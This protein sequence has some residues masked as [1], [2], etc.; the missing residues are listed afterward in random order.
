MFSINL[1]CLVVVVYQIY[2]VK[3]YYDDE[4]K[5]LATSDRNVITQSSM[6]NPPYVTISSQAVQAPVY[7]AQ[8]I[9]YVIH[10]IHQPATQAPYPQQTYQYQPQ[11]QPAP[12]HTLPTD[13][14][15]PQEYCNPPPYSPSFLPESS[16]SSV[17]Q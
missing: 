13:T 8:P 16:S 7:P 1:F 14:F 10:Q 4:L 15:T 6:H 5:F 2:V 11:Q 9:P 3:T 17:K 12:S